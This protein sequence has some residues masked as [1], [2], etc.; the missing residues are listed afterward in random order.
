M[1][2]NHGD[3]KSP[4]D[5]VIPLPNG[6]TSWLINGGPILTTYKSWNEPPSSLGLRES[7]QNDSFI[8]FNVG[9]LLCLD[10]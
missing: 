3:R 1:V 2:N 5:R 9:E 6:R 7:S 8:N 4:K 10:K